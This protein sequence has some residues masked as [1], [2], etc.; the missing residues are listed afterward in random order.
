MH[1]PAPLSPAHP[2]HFE[3]LVARNGSK[4]VQ[5]A[6][7]EKELP[8]STYLGIHPACPQVS[9][10]LPT[11]RV[12]LLPTRHSPDRKGPRRGAAPH[13]LDTQVAGD[14]CPTPIWPNRVW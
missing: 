1:C 3:E 4:P 12:T 5:E 7:G 11:Y 10:G 9:L 2:A 14:E 13:S 6:L 8:C